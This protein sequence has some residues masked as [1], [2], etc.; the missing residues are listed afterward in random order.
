MSLN[1]P[2]IDRG[3]VQIDKF[4]E[5]LYRNHEIVYFNEAFDNRSTFRVTDAFPDGRTHDAQHLATLY[6]WQEER[7]LRWLHKKYVGGILPLSYINLKKKRGRL[8]TL[9]LHEVATY[10]RTDAVSTLELFETLYHRVV[11]GVVSGEF[12]AFERKYAKLVMHL[13]RRG[14]R[15][16]FGWC[17]LKE[18]EFR[19]RMLEIEEELKTLGLRHIGS[20]HSVAAFLFKVLQLPMDTV[21]LTSVKNITWPHGVPSVAEGVMERL[22]DMHPSVKAIREWRQLQ[23]GISKWL[24]E[25]RQH[26]SIDGHVHALLDPFGTVSGRMAASHPN[27]QAIP[28][29]DRGTAFGSMK[30]MFKAE[31]GYCLYACDYSQMEPRLAAVMAR[32]GRLMDILNSGKDPYLQMAEN[33]WG[34]KKRR[35]DAKR[36]TLSGIY[37]IGAEAFAKKWNIHVDRASAILR[38][39]RNA[40]PRIKLAGQLAAREVR[41]SRV[42]RVYTG[43]PRWFGPTEPEYKAFNQ[44]VQLT[45]AEIIKRAMVYVEDYL[46]GVQR[47]QLH[48]AIVSKLPG[49]RGSKIQRD[50]IQQI[51]I[52]TVPE[53]FSE[54][55][56]FVTKVEKWQ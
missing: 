16:D 41:A 35:F 22:E 44:R 26:A 27:V 54:M 6:E 34:D 1:G 24:R 31:K 8:A 19:Q 13:I 9:P 49:P 17:Q 39:F 36:A 38:T 51:M 42:L 23:S 3:E 25:Y 18:W 7:N 46:P 29:S 56:N 4:L 28:M 53:Q 40:F 37:E 30:G 5:S 52:E 48:D 47:L 14:L 45:V 33:I 32:E 50:E 20:N 43:R 2:I 55:V 15:L 10:A 21:P 11:G 12:Y